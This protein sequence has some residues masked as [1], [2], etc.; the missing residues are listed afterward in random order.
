[1]DGDNQHEAQAVDLLEDL[2]FFLR[3][4]QPTIGKKPSAELCSDC[5]SSNSQLLCAATSGHIS[6]IEAALLETASVSSFRTSQ[7]ATAAHIA[8]KRGDADIL[9]KLVEADPTC[10]SSQ[11]TRGTTPTHV[12]AY[13]GKYACLRALV[14]RGGSPDEK[15]HDGA[16]PI[17]L[18]AANG[19]MDCLE[20]LVTQAGGELNNRT[21]SGATPGLCL[22]VSVGDPSISRH[23]VLFSP[24]C[25]FCSLL[26]ST[27]RPSRLSAMACIGC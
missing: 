20:Y 24:T 2:D 1:M 8:A 25:L 18:A 27:R 5:A 17:H 14:E 11:D 6:C 12:S 19:H 21:K 22:P 15:A 23:H 7:G 10:T 4:Q 3:N 9:I 16:T 13:N 26:C